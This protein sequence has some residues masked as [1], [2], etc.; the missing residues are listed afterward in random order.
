VWGGHASKEHDAKI[1]IQKIPKNA[2]K[3]DAED[4]KDTSCHC[5]LGMSREMW[6]QFTDCKLRSHAECT[7]GSTKSVCLKLP[8]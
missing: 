6:I 7:D 2:F 3:T 1:K 8:L 4:S 5:D